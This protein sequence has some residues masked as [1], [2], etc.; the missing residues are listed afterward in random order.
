M[1]HLAV[2]G[3]GSS[4][5]VPSSATKTPASSSMRAFPPASSASA[6]TP[7]RRARQPQAHRP[8]PEHGDHTRG[9]EVF[10]R[11]S[12]IPIYATL[13]TAAI[14]RDGIGAPRPGGNSR[15]GIPSASAVSRSTPSPCRRCR[16][17]RRVPLRMRTHPPSGSSATSAMSPGSSL[18]GSRASTPSSPRPIYDEVLLMNDTKRPGSTKQRIS[19][20]HGH[21]SNDH[22]RRNRRQPSPDRTPP[23]RPRPPQR[24]LQPADLARRRHRRRLQSLGHTGVEVACAPRHAATPLFPVARPPSWPRPWAIYE[25]IPADSPRCANLRARRPS[26]RPAGFPAPEWSQTEWAF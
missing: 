23:R 4:A 7:G 10:C 25:E 19:N 3:S 12:Q 9:L 11:K 26:P 15:R 6:S 1:L 2:L 17:S 24:R 5:T 20:R 16:G 13:H 22:G 8:H 21:L 14:V 18:T